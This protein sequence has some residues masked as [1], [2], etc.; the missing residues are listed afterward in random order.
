MTPA[1]GVPH[2]RASRKLERVLDEH[3]TR[4]HL[5]EVFDAP[6]D[7]VLSDEDVVQPDIIFISTARKEIITTKNIQG[8]PDL[9]VEILSSST[10]T[11]D[12]GTKLRLY[13]RSGVR[14]YWIVDLAAGT[15]EVHEFGSPRRTRIYKEGQSFESAILP[16]LAV[17]LDDIF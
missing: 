5:G 16:G 10:A 11:I 1:P 4:N 3:A 8:A 14:E 7:V 15:M 17:Q 12:R 13:E 9:A 2:Q 6:I